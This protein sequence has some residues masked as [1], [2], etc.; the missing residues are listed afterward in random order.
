M[1]SCQRSTQVFAMPKGPSMHRLLGE[2][3]NTAADCSPYSSSHEWWRRFFVSDSGVR[4]TWVGGQRT[5]FAAR[6]GGGGRR[7]LRRDRYKA[8]RRKRESALRFSAVQLSAT[9]GSALARILVAASQMN[10][11]KP[12][13][14][15]AGVAA[16]TPHK[17]RDLGCPMERHRGRRERRGSLQGTIKVA[18]QRDGCPTIRQRSC[19]QTA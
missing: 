11:R 14:N 4:S 8:P 1:S 16:T 13:R 10:L 6:G 18:G 5:R 19:N 2:P 17:S 7:S 3:G 12:P 15:P 9:A